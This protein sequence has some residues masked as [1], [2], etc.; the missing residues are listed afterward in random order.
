M[1]QAS[2]L[3][4]AASAATRACAEHDPTVEHGNMSG[5]AYTRTTYR[6]TTGKPVMEHW[7]VHGAAHAWFGGSMEGSFSDP[8]GPDASREMLRFFL[9]HEIT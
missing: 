5:R 6:D 7:L 1:E 8:A 4:S 2:E 9:Q 3:S